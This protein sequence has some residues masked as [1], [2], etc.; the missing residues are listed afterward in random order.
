MLVKF[1][2]Q[3]RTT[4]FGIDNNNSALFQLG[5]ASEESRITPNYVHMDVK[6]DDFGPQIPAEV[7]AQMS[8]VN[9]AMRLIHYDRN[10]LDA[11][12]AESLGLNGGN[13]AA[14]IMTPAGYPLGQNLPVLA[15][16]CHYISLNLTSPQLNFPWRFPASFLTGPPVIIPLGTTT[17]IADLNWRT[18]PYAR[19]TPLIEIQSSGRVLWDH[20]PDSTDPFIFVDPEAQE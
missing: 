9:I 13:F 8:D 1:G 7:L 10:V 15:S 11:C 16:G 17:T 19:Q 3:V 12:L 14:G 20:T 4:Q 5:L 18:V 6:V 2:D